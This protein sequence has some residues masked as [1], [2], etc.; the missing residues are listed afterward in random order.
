M[1]RPAGKKGKR[2]VSPRSLANLRPWRPGESPNPGGRPKGM[3]EFLKARYG[4]SGKGLLEELATIAFNKRI[5]AR[6]RVSA[7][8]ELLNRGWGRPTQALEVNMEPAVPLFALPHG[9]DV[10]I[11][12]GPRE[13]QTNECADQDAGKA[14]ACASSGH[15]FGRDAVS[16]QSSGPGARTKPRA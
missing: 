14:S 5:S 9:T 6:V 12:T 3:A 8:S 11:G 15:D 16:S 2:S 4:D 7:L 1:T 10:D 13:C